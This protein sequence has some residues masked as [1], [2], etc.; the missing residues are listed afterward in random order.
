[1]FMTEVTPGSVADRAGVK[2][3]DRLLEVNGESVEG[4]THD[5]VVEKIKVAGS[6]IMFLLL[7]EEAERYYQSKRIKIGVWLA[8]TKY[9]PHKPRIA[10]VAK[11]PDG[12]GFFL[13]KEPNQTG[14]P[15]IYTIC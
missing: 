14:M 4:A 12:Y 15:M 5:Q 7:D 8:T 9:L 3:N 11:G 6:T 1:M 13:R 10:D 2:V